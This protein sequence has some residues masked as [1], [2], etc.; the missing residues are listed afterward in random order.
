M[1]EMKRGCTV[2]TQKPTSTPLA[3]EPIVGSAACWKNMR[4]VRSNIRSMLM[5]L[6]FDC[7]GIVCQ[8]VVCSGQMF[9][10]HYQWEV[11]QCL[12]VTFSQIV[13]NNDGIRAG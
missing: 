3:E 1:Q 11:L 6:M 7:E 5:M 10:Q 13:Q 12:R 2:M 4:Q 8:A 9:Y